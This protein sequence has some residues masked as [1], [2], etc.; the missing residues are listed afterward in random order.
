MD[1]LFTRSVLPIRLIERG[2]CGKS[3]H[4]H[5]SCLLS[6]SHIADDAARNVIVPAVAAGIL[7]TGI[8]SARIARIAD[9]TR[10]PSV[11]R[12]ILED[13]VAVFARR[14]R[15]DDGARLHSD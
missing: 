2:F 4:G 8:T 12:A 5:D 1:Y 14:N 13:E 3:W 15:G 11:I 9:G 7:F 6:H 10:P